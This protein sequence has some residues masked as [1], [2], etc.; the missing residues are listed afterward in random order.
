M[1]YKLTSTITTEPVTIEQARSQIGLDPSDSSMDTLLNTLI[2]AAREYVE[3]YTNRSLIT[4]DWIAYADNFPAWEINLFKLPVTEITSVSYYDV[5]N[6]LQTISANDYDTD[7]VSEPVRI[8]PAYGK[9]WPDTYD[10]LNAVEI[11]FKSGYGAAAT[12]VPKTLQ[13]VILMIITHLEANRGDE[14]FRTLPKTI[15]FLLNDY[16]IELL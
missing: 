14:G 15:D 9:S 3:K 12:D 8:S 11:A 10:K 6:Q 1:I 7:L 4:A 13:A 16:R 2:T 5:N